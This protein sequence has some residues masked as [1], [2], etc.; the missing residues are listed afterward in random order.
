MMLTI[1]SISLV[2][3]FAGIFAFIAFKQYQ[4]NKRLVSQISDLQSQ[5]TILT[6]GAVGIDQRLSQFE[7]TLKTLQERQMSLSQAIAPQNDYD[8]A[9]RLAQKGVDVGQLIDTCNLTDEEA[10]I[11][12][13]MHGAGLNKA[14]T[15]LVN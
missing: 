7:S 2:T 6:S 8:H 14:R 4:Y 1:I 5:L 10:H 11:I 12:E 15:S 3:I 13:R 9:I